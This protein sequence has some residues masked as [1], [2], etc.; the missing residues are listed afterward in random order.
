MKS[1]NRIFPA[2]LAFTLLITETVLPCTRIVYEGLNGTINGNL[3][4]EA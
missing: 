3:N 4:T 1:K 2:L